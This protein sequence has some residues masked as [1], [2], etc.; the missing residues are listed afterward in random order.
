MQKGRVFIMGD[1]AHRH[2]P[3]N[4][5]GSNTS[6]QDGFNLAW[7]LAAVIKGQAGPGL[8]DSYSEERA[9]VAKQIVSRANKSIAEFGPIFEALGMGERSDPE[10][11][12][13]E[14]GQALARPTWRGRAS[15]RGDPRAPSPYKKYEFDCARRGNEPPLQ[16]PALSSPMVSWNRLSMFDEELHYQPTTWPGARYAACLGA[17]ISKGATQFSSL[18]LVG[19]GRFTVL[20]GIGGDGWVEAAKTVRRRIR[21]GHRHGVIGHR[22][23]YI[24]FAGDWARAREINDGGVRSGAPR[25][26]WSLGGMKPT[27]R[28]DH[29]CLPNCAESCRASWHA[30]GD[31]DGSA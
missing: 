27:T 16:K 30:E 22:R 28:S 13:A 21:H 8:L 12:D 24:D 4:G 15:T 9:P 14:P 5:L 26:T 31:D 2:P 18:D 10:R 29:G 6:I 7:K 19:R 11:L 20:T 3:S 25:P 17:T 1:A 23:G